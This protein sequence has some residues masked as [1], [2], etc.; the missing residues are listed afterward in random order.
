MARKVVPV[1]QLLNFVQHSVT[2]FESCLNDSLCNDIMTYN[3][4]NVT[5]KYPIDSIFKII[6]DA[7]N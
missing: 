6:T 5:K 4:I 2:Y 7:R 1:Q 3:L